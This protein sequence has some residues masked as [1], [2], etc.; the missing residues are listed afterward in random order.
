MRDLVKQL[1]ALPLLGWA[2]AQRMLD[3]PRPEAFRILLFHDVPLAQRAALRRL[4]GDLARRGVL[5]SPADAGR[6]LAG[7]AAGSSAAPGVLLSFDDGF[8]SNLEVAE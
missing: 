6:R 8:A 3:R 1:A 4:V 7:A 5:I 2:A